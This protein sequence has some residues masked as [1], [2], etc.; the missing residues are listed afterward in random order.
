LNENSQLVFNGETNQYIREL[1]T[2]DF[3]LIKNTC[4]WYNDSF[5]DPKMSSTFIIWVIKEI[6]K[7]ISIF[8]NQVLKSK[9]NFSIARECIETTNEQIKMV[10]I[11]M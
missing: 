4:E 11:Y 5:K 7:Y 10:Y 9:S 2:I 8:R 3:T 6:D 1:A